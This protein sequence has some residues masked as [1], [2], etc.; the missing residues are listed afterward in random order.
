[1]TMQVPEPVIERLVRIETKLDTFNEIHG[2][3]EGRSNEIHSDHE[4]RIRKLERSVWL[5]A[6]AATVIGGGAGALLGPV[7]RA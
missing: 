2:A 4:S 6:G 7:L 1:M 3:H 5:M